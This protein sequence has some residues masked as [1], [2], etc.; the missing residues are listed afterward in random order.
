MSSIDYNTTQYYNGQLADVPALYVREAARGAW[1]TQ[2]ASKRAAAEAQV[3]RTY[4]KHIPGIYQY[5]L[6]ILYNTPLVIESC[7]LCVV[8]MSY[9]S[10]RSVACVA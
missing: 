10:D 1:K 9:V 4:D 5:I 6:E 7:F 3:L 8:V 2:R